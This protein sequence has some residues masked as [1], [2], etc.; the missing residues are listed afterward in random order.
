MTDD[1]I[2]D[3]LAC[4]PDG[5]RETDSLVA[6][7]IGWTPSIV[8]NWS[9]QM[10]PPGGDGSHV[11][12]VPCYTSDVMWCPV[13]LEQLSVLCAELGWHVSLQCVR[14]GR[15]QVIAD[16]MRGSDMQIVRPGDPRVY[17]EGT[18]LDATW[19]TLLKVWQRTQEVHDGCDVADGVPEIVGH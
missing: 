2:D 7:A 9:W 8:G 5:I 1:E 3:L 13:L 4:E 14:P 19:K 15:W 16:G 17:S 10:I 6:T 12:H 18:L 11:R